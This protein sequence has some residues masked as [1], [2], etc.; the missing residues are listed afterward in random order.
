VALAVVS[1]LVVFLTEDVK[2]LRLAVVAAAWAVVVATLVAVRRRADQQ[3]LAERELELRRVHDRELDLEAAARRELELE[4]EN[5]VRRETE[6]ALHGEFASL[7]ADLAAL[8]RLRDD[9]AGVAELRGDLQGLSSLRADLRADLGQLPELRS[10]LSRLR[11]E[12]AEQLSGELLVERIIMRTQGFRLPGEERS[13]PATGSL[14]APTWHQDPASRELA[15][16]WT[17]TRL[18]AAQPTREY[19]PVRAER[20]LPETQQR[21]PLEWLAERSLLDVP[22]PAVERRPDW[23]YADSEPFEAPPAARDRSAARDRIEPPKPVPFRRR[24]TDDGDAWQAGSPPAESAVTVERP[25][26]HAPQHSAPAPQHSAPAPQHSAP[27]P[28]HG[29]PAHRPP[30]PPLR[31]AGAR[32]ATPARPAGAHEAPRPADPAAAPPEA[33]G[34]T[35]LTEILAETGNTVPPSGGRRRRRYRDDDD[36]DDVLSRVLRGD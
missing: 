29:A 36:P 34:H 17:A 14:D 11:A 6:E 24:H 4:I 26:A 20:P 7:R 31:P 18:D 25:G 10:D 19:Q 5:D 13:Q 22:E 3:R 21:T 1:S 15:G 27:A 28:Q 33:A 16:G 12:L 23:P 2:V 35:R 9:L 30:L 32:E 8:T